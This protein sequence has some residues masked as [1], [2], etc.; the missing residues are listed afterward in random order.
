MSVDQGVV[1]GVIH[2]VIAWLALDLG[3]HSGRVCKQMLFTIL[4]EM[5]PHLR[6]T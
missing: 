5:D 1:G 4:G 3:D 2:L 6:I